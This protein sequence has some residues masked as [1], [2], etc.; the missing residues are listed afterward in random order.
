M[1]ALQFFTSAARNLHEARDRAGQKQM[2]VV[3]I[4]GID[5]FTGGYSAAN[6]AHEQAM[7]SGPV[8]VEVVPAALRALLPADLPENLVQQ[9]AGDAARVRR[10]APSLFGW[11]FRR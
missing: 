7:M 11:L 5:R 1:S 6:L 3:S 4:I 8:P 9:P 2:I 10:V